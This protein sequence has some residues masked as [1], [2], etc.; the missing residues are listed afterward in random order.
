[1]ARCHTRCRKCRTRRVLPKKPLSYIE[2]PL[3]PCGGVLVRDKWMEERDT[4]AMS[5]RCDG[6]HFVPHRMGSRQQDR[7]CHYMPNGECR[8][9]EIEP[10]KG[11]DLPF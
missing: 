6:L 2:P 5:C 7:I 4:K 8:Y 1:M 11:L 3:C 10:M 9:G